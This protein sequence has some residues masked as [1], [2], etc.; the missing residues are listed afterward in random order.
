[1]H[2]PAHNKRIITDLMYQIIAYVEKSHEPYKVI[3]SPF[4]IQLNQYPVAI[5]P[6]LAIIRYP[7]KITTLQIDSHP[8]FILDIATPNAPQPDPTAK[9]NLYKELGIREYWIID[10]P[11][12]TLSTYILCSKTIHSL[13][14]YEMPCVRSTLALPMLRLCLNFS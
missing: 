12:R 6:D 5:Y 3:T 4:Y 9:L 8:L 2:P 13:K 11:N 10:W 14:R 7:D 1:M